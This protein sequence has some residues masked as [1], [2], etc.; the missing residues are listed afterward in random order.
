MTCAL[1][2]IGTGP[3]GD[4]MPLLTLGFLTGILLSVYAILHWWHEDGVRGPGLPWRS[5]R[6]YVRHFW[7]GPR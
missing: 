2:V 6:H 3:D 4:A 7:A 5:G 1:S